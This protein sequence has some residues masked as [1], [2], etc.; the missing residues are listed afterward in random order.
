MDCTRGS[1]RILVTLLTFKLASRKL[2]ICVRAH[3]SLVLAMWAR[4][5]D[6][7]PPRVCSCARSVLQHAPMLTNSVCV[8][9][10]SPRPRNHGLRSVLH[11]LHIHRRQ[12]GRAHPAPRPEGGQVSFPPP[13]ARYIIEKSKDVPSA[14]HVRLATVA[15]AVN[16]GARRCPC[17]CTPRRAAVWHSSR[18]S[19][20]GYP[21]WGAAGGA[22]KRG[23]AC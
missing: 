7:P 23:R 19:A 5:V 14:S 8:S 3:V 21:V 13:I 6:A 22:R 4:V 10:P 1:A 15:S 9:H 18:R 2:M 17:R 12:G 11:H 16:A 20:W